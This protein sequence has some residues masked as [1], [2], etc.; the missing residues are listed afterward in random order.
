MAHSKDLIKEIYDALG[1]SDSAKLQAQLS[2]NLEVIQVGN[3]GL[4]GAFRGRKAFL[5]HLADIPKYCDGLKIHPYSILEGS[6]EYAA[7][8]NLMTIEKE[9]QTR[10]LRGIHLF[11]I[12]DDKVIELRSVP[13]DPYGLDALIG[14]SPRASMP[15]SSASSGSIASKLGAV[16]YVLWGILHVGVAWQISS[17]A[18]EIG[19]ASIAARTNQL[20]FYIGAVGVLA[21]IFAYDNWPNG[22]IGYWANL[23]MVS[24]MDIGYVWFVVRVV[25]MPLLEAWLGP[26]LWM[27]ALI[28]ST[29]A[30]LRRSNRIATTAEVKS[31]VGR[32]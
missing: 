23:L 24:L 25:D 12:R 3:N 15:A 10:T 22:K 30:Y 21:I 19:A 29:T 20:A 4:A 9:G 28:L 7:S 17:A 13:E 11:R 8:L 32:E 18:S 5:K 16:F 1:R 2:E 26:A 31:G 27:V 6:D 14:Q